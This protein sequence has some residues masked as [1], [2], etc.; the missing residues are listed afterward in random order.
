[1][2]WEKKTRCLWLLDKLKRENTLTLEEYECLSS[3]KTLE[4]IYYAAEHAGEVR[5]E[6]Y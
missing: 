5:K 1:M 3:V 2:S 6:V 4:L